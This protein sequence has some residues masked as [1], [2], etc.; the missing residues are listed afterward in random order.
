MR[1]ARLRMRADQRKCSRSHITTTVKRKSQRSSQYPPSKY[2]FDCARRAG[3]I[4]A[5]Y[6]STAAST[7]NGLAVPDWTAGVEL[8]VVEL[9]CADATAVT[10]N[11][12]RN[13]DW[14]KRSIRWISV[15]GEEYTTG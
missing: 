4:F 1:S 9:F 6:C 11:T 14:I 7:L 2:A 15:G 12:A 8:V 10:S 13:A 5:R 3:G